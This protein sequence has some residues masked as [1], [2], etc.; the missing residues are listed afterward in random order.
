M[1]K[2]YAMSTVIFQLMNSQLIAVCILY[3][4]GKIFRYSSLLRHARVR[5]Y[6]LLSF[7]S[8]LNAS[9]NIFSHSFFSSQAILFVR[10][11]RSFFSL[12][13]LSLLGEMWFNKI[14]NKQFFIKK[15]TQALLSMSSPIII[16]NTTNYDNNEYLLITDTK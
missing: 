8:H 14:H 11:V 12:D 6:T 2:S 5:S 16:M 9:N 10:F 4:I 1:R 7:R 13:S 15:K 3:Q